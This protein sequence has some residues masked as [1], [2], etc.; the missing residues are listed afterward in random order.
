M[1]LGI[2]GLEKKM[3]EE[4]RNANAT[5]KNH[6]ENNTT[7]SAAKNQQ[8]FSYDILQKEFDNILHLFQKSSTVKD[9]NNNPQKEKVF[10]EIVHENCLPKNAKRILDEFQGYGPLESILNKPNINEIIINNKD[11]IFYEQNGH[12]VKHEDGFLS[13]ITFNNI[14]ERLCSESHLSLNYKKPFAEGKWKQFRIHIT[15]P[16]IVIKDFHISL[17]KHP[18]EVW[19]LDKLA[20]KNWAPQ[21]AIQIIKD[22][23]Y[24]GDNFLIVGST[25]SGKTSVLNACLQELPKNERVITIEDADELRLPNDASTKLL[26]QNSQ[27][28]SLSLISQDDLL[29]QSLR[30]RP[31]R[32]VMGEVRGAEA[33]N[34]LLALSSGHKGSIGTLHASHHK[35]AISKLEMLTQMGATQ[36]QSTTVQRLIHLSLQAVIVVEKI[37]DVRKLKGVY[38]ISGLE[39]SGFLYDTLYE[40]MSI[41]Q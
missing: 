7:E 27:E 17:R 4:G 11:C 6:I 23:I 34:L 24:Q 30:L 18:K 33:K 22:L 19:T 21:H 10:K 3:I 38:K 8:E 14:V 25:S 31:D 1:E 12:L 32:L 15:R 39:S 37:K 28:S 35:Q 20:Q 13:Q 40:K 5:A 2:Y 26:T 41:Q 9:E 29:K 36:W 16:P